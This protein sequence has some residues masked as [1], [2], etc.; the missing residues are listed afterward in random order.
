M[1]SVPGVA[2]PKIQLMVVQA[3]P[4]CNID[5]KYCYLPDRRS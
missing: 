2:V 4:F 5:C 3:T 1:Q